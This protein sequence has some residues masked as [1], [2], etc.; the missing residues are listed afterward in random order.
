MTWMNLRGVMLDKSHQSHMLSCFFHLYE[1]SRRNQEPKC[2][3]NTERLTVGME[4]L[5]GLMG[6]SGCTLVMAL[7]LCGCAETL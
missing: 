2:G 3:Q 5:K 4:V 7:K 1:P 6:Y